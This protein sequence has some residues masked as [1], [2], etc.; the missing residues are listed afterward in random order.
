MNKS[1]S[2]RPL[3]HRPDLYESDQEMFYVQTGLDTLVETTDLEQTTEKQ[4]TYVRGGSLLGEAALLHLTH[5]G[6]IPLS[7][8]ICVSSFCF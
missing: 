7:L 8:S 6:F 3:L 5:S 2:S 1:C 4:E